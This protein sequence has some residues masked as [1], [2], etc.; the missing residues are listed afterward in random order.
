M[1]KRGQVT[2]FMIVGL[3]I[4]IIVVLLFGLRRAGIG[5][6]SEDFLQNNLDDIKKNIDTCIEEQTAEML[7]ILG[8]QGGY[9]NPTKYKMY[10][11]YRVA[12]LC[13]NV[14][15]TDQCANAMINTADIEKQLAS[16]L[17]VNLPSC[18][19]VDKLGKGFLSNYD[20]EAGTLDT[21]A[22]ITNDAIIF[23]INYPITLKKGDASLTMSSYPKSVNVPLGLLLDT[24]YDIVNNEAKYGVFFEVPYMLAERGAVEIYKDQPYP[25]KIYVLNARDSKYIFQFGIESEGAHE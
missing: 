2:S 16:Y 24:T 17:N 23:D 13:Y 4:L 19:Q 6:K 8:K 14:P 18:I 11:G 9:L 1:R 3:V 25:D 15:D 10:N 22:I 20:A 12:Y 21:K 7:D 5:V